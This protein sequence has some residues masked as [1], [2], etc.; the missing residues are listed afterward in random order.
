MSYVLL[1]L[2]KRPE[3]VRKFAGSSA[4]DELVYSRRRIN[5]FLGIT[6]RRGD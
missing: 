6:D 2:L 4:V 5:L 1:D 3:V